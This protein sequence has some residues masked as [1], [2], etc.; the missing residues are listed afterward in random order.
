MKRYLLLAV[1][2][3]AAC[4]KT[5]SNPAKPAPTPA[6]PAP[7]PA[8][9]TPPAPAADPYQTLIDDPD[10]T[11]EDRAEDATRKPLELLR[12]LKLQPGMKVADLGAGGGYLTELLA[13]AVGPSGVVY[14]QNSKMVIEKFVAKEWPARLARPINKNVVRVDR[15]SVEPL[16]PEAKDLDLVTMGFVY[17]DMVWWK[18]DRDK[19]NAAIFAALKPGGAFVVLDHEAGAG[20]GTTVTESL[21]RIEKQSVIDE[22][23][24]AGF[25]LEAEGTFLANPD[26]PHDETV[27]GKIR[28][29]SDRFVLR[30]VK[31]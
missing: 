28:G 15:E 5:E 2:L 9:P 19:M 18:V 1:F 7:E 24:R 12:F 4:G 10:R 27:F 16:P 14:A 31:P 30:F 22:V 29:K 25:K 23:T 26:D 6:K 20:K 3:V 8:K 17:H 21:H 13:R 11:A